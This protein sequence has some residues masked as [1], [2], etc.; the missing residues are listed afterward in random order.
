[1]DDYFLI[2]KSLEGDE[3]SFRLLI[4]KYEKDLTCFVKRLLAFS[5]DHFDDVMQNIVIKIFYNL[6]KYN[7]S[8]S[9]KNWIYAIAANEVK[10][11]YKKYKRTNSNHIYIDEKIL[12]KLKSTYNPEDD[13][14]KKEFLESLYY[15]IEN[16]PIKQKL[17]VKLKYFEDFKITEIAKILKM[18][19]RSVKYK[20][21]DAKKIIEKKLIKKG[22]ITN[23]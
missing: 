16:L 17:V 23:F 5:G 8:F 13:F 12:N 15:I 10:S 7:N 9:F 3:K 18:S 4:N 6:K 11:Y 19:E 1:M 22:F 14:L 2:Q 21:K 20:L